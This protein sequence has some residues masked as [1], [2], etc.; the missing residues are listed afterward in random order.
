MDRAIGDGLKR[1]EPKPSAIRDTLKNPTKVIL[2]YDKD[3]RKSWQYK[4]ARANVVLNSKGKIVSTNP[5]GKGNSRQGSSGRGG[6]R[7]TIDGPS[8]ATRTGTGGRGGRAMG[9]SMRVVGPMAPRMRA[10]Q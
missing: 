9:G 6:G 2:K 5:R 7:A 8:G 3:G 4:G 10:L 1:K